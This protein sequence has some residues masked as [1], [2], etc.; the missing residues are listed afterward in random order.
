MVH[1]AA[2]AGCEAWSLSWRS[3]EPLGSGIWDLVA[4]K[5]A[6]QLIR[7]PFHEPTFGKMLTLAWFSFLSSFV[8]PSLLPFLPP[9][10]LPFLPF[11]FSSFNKY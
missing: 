3:S 1:R 2:S 10:L 9:P 7:L 6:M 5:A 8:T 4:T 11:P